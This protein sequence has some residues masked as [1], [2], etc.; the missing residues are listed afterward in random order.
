MMF[1]KQARTA[2]G[3]ALRRLAPT[4]PRRD[5]RGPRTDSSRMTLKT[6]RV[7]GLLLALAACSSKPEE[8]TLG[9]GGANGAGAGSP[10]ADSSAAGVSGSEVGNKAQPGTQQDL[11]VNVGDRVFFGYDSST[12]D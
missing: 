7:A 9:T 8:Q 3:K 12:V 10:L 11:E 6:L 5:A 4:A 2:R 1:L